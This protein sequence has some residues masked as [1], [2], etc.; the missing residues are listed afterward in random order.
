M[1][2]ETIGI[3]DL[4]YKAENTSTDVKSKHIDTKGEGKE[5]DELGNCD[6]HIYAIDPMYKIDN[7]WEPTVSHR[8]LYPLVGDD[9]RGQEI[10]KRGDICIRIADLLC[11]YTEEINTTL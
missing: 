1:E 6:W 7:Q 4:I 2:S 10:Q 3:D 8:E 5:W 11:Y 9:P